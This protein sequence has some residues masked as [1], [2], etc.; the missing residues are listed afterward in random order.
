MDKL[1]L[2]DVNN[3]LTKDTKD[4][5]EY[6]SESIRN[7][8]GILV[9]LNLSK[10][11]GM[12]SQE[13]AEAALRETGMPQEEIDEKLVRYTEDLFYSYYNVAGHDRQILLD[14]AKELL[15]ELQN[16]EVL[17]GIATGEAERVAKFRL[18]K[19]D[20]SKYFKF[21]AF[22]KDAK[23]ADGIVRIALEKAKNDFTFSGNAIA[24]CGDPAF[25]KASKLAGMMSVGVANGK[26]SAEDLKSA[27]A[28]A[29]IKSLREKGKITNL[30][31]K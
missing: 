14:G 6:V 20:L 18:E 21:G 22:G 26:F 16:K 17:I 25:L 31:A 11:P 3:I 28:D 5:S 29:V 10:Y 15:E 24:V 12:T 1:V 9:E 4:V 30:L 8:Y 2:F 13:I 19:T 7:I 23:D 27:G